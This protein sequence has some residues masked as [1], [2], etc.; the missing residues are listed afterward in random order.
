MKDVTTPSVGHRRWFLYPP[1]KV[2]GIGAT[3]SERNS[4]YTIWV[5]RKPESR[6]SSP[7]WV[8]WPPRGYVPFKILPGFWS[9]SYPN[10]S[11]R[12]AK[13]TMRHNGARISVSL[14][15]VRNGYGDNTLVWKPKSLPTRAPLEDETYSVA[16]SG[17]SIGGSTRSFN[18]EVT[19]IDPG[20]SR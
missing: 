15:K 19:V 14:Q 4:A 7:E 11:F 8:A 6:P 16:I 2:M 9:F 20:R 1:H 13:V 5:H 17:V 10:A 18:Y 12:N 3:F